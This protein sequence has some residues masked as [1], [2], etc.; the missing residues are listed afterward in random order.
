MPIILEHLLK[1]VKKTRRPSCSVM[2]FAHNRP[3][4]SKRRGPTI[5]PENLEEAA[6]LK[7]LYKERATLSQ[8]EFGAQSGLGTQGMVW[9]Y[10]NGKAAL[11]LRA[12]VQFSKMLGCS[13]GDFSSR[14]ANEQQRLSAPSDPTHY[15][16]E[17]GPAHYTIEDATANLVATLKDATPERVKLALAQLEYDL[18]QARGTSAPLIEHAPKKASNF[19]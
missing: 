13:I 16:I 5:T 2:S 10:L 11:H 15:T 6:T 3:M 19:S 7:A 8:A 17:A 9:Q 1:G 12:A 18:S 14:L 4:T